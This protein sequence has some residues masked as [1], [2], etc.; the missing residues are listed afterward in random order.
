MS[1][2]ASISNF[3]KCYICNR[4]GDPLCNKCFSKLEN[5]S[6][7][8]NVMGVNLVSFYK[9]NHVASK[10]LLISKYPP[11][12]FYILKYLIRKTTLPCFDEKSIFCPVPINSLR[13]FERKFNQAELIAD[14]FAKKQKILVYPILK[15]GRDTNP[16]FNLNYFARKNELK[17][18]FKL[19]FFGY[20][21]SQ[22]STLKILLVDDLVTTSQTLRECIKTLKNCGFTNIEA[23]SLFRA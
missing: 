3:G 4:D 8:E 15:R 7:V 13:M 12:Y 9:Y 17:N 14:E 16:L 23:Y 10:I 20:I 21:I 22:K 6:R 11:Y 2:L 1:F 18:A 19:N 5:V